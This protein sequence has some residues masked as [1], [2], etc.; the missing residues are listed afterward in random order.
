MNMGDVIR[1]NRMNCGL[2][3]EELG[4]ICSILLY[5]SPAVTERRKEIKP[6]LV[7]T[8]CHGLMYFPEANPL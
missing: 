7:S 8:I 2:T 6:R 5:Y 1:M 4:K 3:Q